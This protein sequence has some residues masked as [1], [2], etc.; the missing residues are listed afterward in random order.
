MIEVKKA[1]IY[2]SG[3]E[4]GPGVS[5]IILSLSSYIDDAK[6]DGSA[7]WTSKKER[8]IVSIYLSN[9]EGEHITG[10]SSY[11]T[12]ELETII[13]PNGPR[14]PFSFNINKLQNEWASEYKVEGRIEVTVGNKDMNINFEQD[15]IKNRFCPDTERFK[16]RGKHSG[17]YQ[18]PRREEIISLSL[19]Y[20]GYEPKELKEDGV[21]NP[22][23]I[24]LNGQGEGGTDV[25]IALLGN[26]VTSLSKPKIQKYFTTEN[27]SNGAYVLVVQCPTY[28][29]DGGENGVYCKG[30]VESIYT[31]ILN[32]LINDYI[33]KNG[34]IDEDRIYIG[35]CSNGGYMA[36]NMIIKYP[37]RWA[38]CYQTCEA[39]KFY[40]GKRDENGEYIME[41]GA[42]SPN[43]VV[44][45]DQRFFTDEKINAIKDIPIWFVHSKTDK[46]AIG[47]RYSFPSYQ[48][49]LKAGAKNAW[50]SYFENVKSSENKEFEYDGHWSWV[51]LFNDEVRKVQNRELIM[52]SNDLKSFGLIANN[53]GGG[54]EFARDEKRI[55]RCLFEWLNAQTK[56]H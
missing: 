32:D 21:K 14:C 13:D 47:W 30:D 44:E 22:L 10:K 8:K 18:H 55:Y 17:K 46:L 7:I 29:M 34:D 35:G 43:Q 11:I 39:Y 25:D 2:I 42:I 37:S 41:E 5:K 31:N 54:D 20:A 3:Y 12:L 38:A 15:C 49:L 19:Q 26:E 51:L 27:G 4:W 9:A 33:N 56:S 53:D 6:K 36:M 50:F 40:I 48:E 23:I 28:W 1:F 52:K 16:V 45:T 24:W